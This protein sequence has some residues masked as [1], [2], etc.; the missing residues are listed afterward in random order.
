MAD[1]SGLLVPIAAVSW[2]IAILSVATVDGILIPAV[3]YS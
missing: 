1:G 3:L 2:L